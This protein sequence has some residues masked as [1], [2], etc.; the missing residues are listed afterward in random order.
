MY[1][2]ESQNAT[3]GAFAQL[4]IRG[5]AAAGALRPAV[6]RALASQPGLAFHFHDFQA[7]ISG[8]RS[9]KTG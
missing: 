3:P 9:G 6:S 8:T 1:L 5:R 7:H 2:A 4:L